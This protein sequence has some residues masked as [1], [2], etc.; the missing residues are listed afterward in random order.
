LIYGGNFTDDY[1]EG[2]GTYYF[3]DEQFNH[4]NWKNGGTKV[5]EL[6]IEDMVPKTGK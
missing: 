5:M 3:S 2:S 6:T 1:F 4:D